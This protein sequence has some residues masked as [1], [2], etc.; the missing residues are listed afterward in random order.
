[1]LTKRS[2]LTLSCAALALASFGTAGTMP[3]QAKAAA[4]SAEQQ[5][6]VNK[7]NAYFNRVKTLQGDFVQVGPNG[8]RAKGQFAIA[9]PGKVRFRYAPPARIDIIADGKAVVIKDRKLRTQDLYPLSQTPLRFLLSSK[10]N[11]QRDAKVLSVTADNAYS[12]ILV[13]DETTFG[14]SKLH[15]IFDNEPFILKQWTITD[16]QGLDTT[17][18]IY[19]AVEDKPISNKI[20]KI[21]KRRRKV[22]NN[23]K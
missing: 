18:A 16:A 1:M 19:N 23:D 21:Q 14:S 11:L 9:R 17:V 12:K 3:G 2:F 22:G 7:A 13:K 10:I 4:L 15:L 6:I 20:F 5:A 8:G